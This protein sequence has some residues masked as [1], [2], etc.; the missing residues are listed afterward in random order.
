[1]SLNSRGEESLSMG[2]RGLVL[3]VDSIISMVEEGVSW[4]GCY[5]AHSC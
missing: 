4:K 2:G 1:M 5:P 3:T